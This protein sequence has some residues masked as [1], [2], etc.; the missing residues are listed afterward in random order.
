MATYFLFAP[1]FSHVFE[2]SF[3]ECSTL[4]EQLTRQNSDLL[5]KIAR[6]R[7]GELHA[8]I[9]FEVS[10]DGIRQI[11]RVWY[12]IMKKLRRGAKECPFPI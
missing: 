11:H 10:A 4:A 12:P 5:L 1:N 7:V 9:I 3:G 8:Q 6:V 2:G